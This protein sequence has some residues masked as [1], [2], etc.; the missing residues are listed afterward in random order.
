MMAKALEVDG[1]RR[2]TAYGG[3]APAPWPD[4][5]SP[6]KVRWGPP[7]A[8]PCLKRRVFRV[9]LYHLRKHCKQ[10]RHLS[11]TR[12]CP[13]LLL[14]ALFTSQARTNLLD[15]PPS[16]ASLSRVPASPHR[17]SP[18]WPSHPRLPFYSLPLAGWPCALG[19]SQGRFSTAFY[20]G[21]PSKTKRANRP[22]CPV[23][24]LPACARPPNLTRAILGNPRP[25]ESRISLL[26]CLV[27][28]SHH[29]LFSPFQFN[30][31]HTLW[32][33][34][35]LFQTRRAKCIPARF[36]TTT[37]CPFDLTS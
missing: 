3:P 4:K 35:Q 36:A 19:R 14:P 23:H 7:P 26:G 33:F 10:M 34:S 2:A 21:C 20:G 31:S 13:S 5:G 25:L 30:S 17:A 37:R 24:Q 22:S 9:A 16:V 11:W 32:V 8:P 27:H 15:G 1:P 6:G 28:P 18:T 29:L 12:S